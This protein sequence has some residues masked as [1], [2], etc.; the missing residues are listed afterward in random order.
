MPDVQI[1]HHAVGARYEARVGSKMAGFAKHQLA[2]DL[3][4][5]EALLERGPTCTSGS[6]SQHIPRRR[7]GCARKPRT[8]AQPAVLSISRVATPPLRSSHSVAIGWTPPREGYSQRMREFE[9]VQRAQYVGPY[10]S[11]PCLRWHDHYLRSCQAGVQPFVAR[12]NSQLVAAR[13]REMLASRVWARCP[14]TRRAASR[15][16]RKPRVRPA[17]VAHGQR[18]GFLCLETRQVCRRAHTPTR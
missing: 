1:S 17:V 7:L 6:R 12:R 11:R 9:L 15:Y 5:R 3:L 13:M 4:Q 16:G 8:E 18:V 2:R 10:E 14:S